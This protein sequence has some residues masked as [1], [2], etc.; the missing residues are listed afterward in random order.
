MSNESFPLWVPF[1]A[2][3]LWLFVGALLSELSGWP[4]L[5]RAHPDQA[6][7]RGHRLRGQV[8]A[9]GWVSENNVTTIEATPVGLRLTTMFL[10][11][12]RR[13]TLLVPWEQI[14]G[15]SGRRLLWARWY[16]LDLGGIT[17]V[18][19]KR[20]AWDVIRPHLVGPAAS[21]AN[22]LTMES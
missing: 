19:V 4:E 9:M 1:F 13:P 12:F 16:V 8:T 22:R 14:R 5:A 7:E 17:T 15:V 11:R 10:F 3:A 18:S 21:D 6:T 20:R 2:V